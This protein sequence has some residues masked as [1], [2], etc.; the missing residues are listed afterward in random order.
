MAT[1]TALSVYHA[2]YG[3]RSAWKFSDRQVDRMAI[4]KMLDAAIWAPN[5]RLT[6]SGGKVDH[7]GGEK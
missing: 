7:R 1:T 2:I 6:V 5:H 3:R 4:E